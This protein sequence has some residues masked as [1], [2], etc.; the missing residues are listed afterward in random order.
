MV[1][2]ECIRVAVQVS[3]KPCELLL[4]RGKLLLRSLERIPGGIVG[5]FWRKIVGNQLLLALKVDHVE[6]DIFLRLSDL[7]LHVA[8]AGLERN[9]IVT[10]ISDLSLGAIQ[11]QLKLQRIQLEQDVALGDAARPKLSQLRRLGDVTRGE[12]LAGVPE[13][14]T[15]RLLKTLQA[16]KANLTVCDSPVAGQK[17]VSHG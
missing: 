6:V 4:Q 3:G 15:E 8:V 2:D 11:C 17:R 13:A 12:A 9:E 10:R 7:G 14:D 1:F 5:S 16:L